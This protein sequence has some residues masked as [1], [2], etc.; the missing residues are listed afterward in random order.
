MGHKRSLDE[1][2]GSKNNEKKNDKKSITPP[3]SAKKRKKEEV[4]PNQF[5][6]NNFLAKKSPNRQ[7]PNNTSTSSEQSSFSSTPN[8][9]RDPGVISLLSQDDIMHEPQQTPTS[10]NNSA[11]SMNQTPLSGAGSRLTTSLSPLPENFST[12]NGEEQGNLKFSIPNTALDFSNS[13]N[14]SFNSV[15]AS[16]VNSEQNDHPDQAAPFQNPEPITPKKTIKK[17]K[18]N[19]PYYTNFLMTI[20]NTQM[21]VH[22]HVFNEEERG[23]VEIFRNKFMRILLN[24]QKIDEKYFPEGHCTSSPKEIEIFGQNCQALLARVPFFLNF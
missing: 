21:S 8:H 11:M 4:P 23:I 7:S 13:F 18:F 12:P 1:A 20:L 6:L 16:P 15:D 9:N 17:R 19:C 3:S 5:T 2:N 10:L 22:S 24:N 14:S